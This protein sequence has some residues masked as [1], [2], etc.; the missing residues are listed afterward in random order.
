MRLFAGWGFRS[1]ARRQS[2]SSCWEQACEQL[3]PSDMAQDVWTFA[4]LGSKSH[5]SAW[6]E[7]E[8]WAA[9]AIPGATRLDCQEN[10]IRHV[11]TQSVSARLLQRFA[12]GSVSE[13]LALHAANRHAG[14]MADRPA[15]PAGPQSLHVPG[16]LY[17]RLVLPRIVSAD[18]RATLA[19]AGLALAS[20]PFETGVFL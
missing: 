4:A 3:V 15:V 16:R 13:A 7:L 5:T 18:R 8:T 20:H 11:A 12:T 17:G 14:C 10:D 9:A 1:D 19:V 6:R 2:F